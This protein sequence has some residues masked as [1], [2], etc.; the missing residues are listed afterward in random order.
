[1][2]AARIVTLSNNEIR[3]KDLLDKL[4]L[5]VLEDG[6]IRQFVISM[7]K[8]THNISPRYDESLFTHM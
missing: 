3:F 1:M 7:Y 5:E 8:I 6:G 2:R 4:S